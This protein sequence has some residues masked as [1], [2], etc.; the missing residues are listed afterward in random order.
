MEV[1]KENQRKVNGHEVLALNESLQS[2][3]MSAKEIKGKVHYSLMRNLKFL[4]PHLKAIDEAKK[5]IV[6]SFAEKSENGQPSILED[7]QIE[8]SDENRVLATQ[9]FNEILDAE[10][11]VDVYEI[12]LA[13]YEELVLDFSKLR[14]SDLFLD[15]YIVE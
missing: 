2:V 12:P 10:Y 5:T 11:M 14:F 6:E 3:L 4:A 8:Y 15:T 7:G 9:A 13:L 1:V